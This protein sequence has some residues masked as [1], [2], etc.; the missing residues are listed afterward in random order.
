MKLMCQELSSLLRVIGRSW[1]DK[2]G[3]MHKAME[4][5]EVDAMIVTGLDETACTLHKNSSQ[6][7]NIFIFVTTSNIFFWWMLLL[8][9]FESRLFALY[10]R[11]V[12]FTSS[13]Y[14]LQPVFPVLH[15]CR[16]TR[17]CHN[18]RKEFH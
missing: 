10:C 9:C 5:K 18:V 15:N 12:E 13:R 17:E 16:K 4:E 1:Q 7:V 11:A 3:D 14:R 6:G 8:L 2:I